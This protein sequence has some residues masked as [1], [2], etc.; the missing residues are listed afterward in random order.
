MKW[1]LKAL[2]DDVEAVHGR[3][4]ERALAPC[5]QSIVKR[6]HYAQYHFA[7]AHRLMA[8]DLS[9]RDQGAILTELILPT[10]PEKY[11]DFHRRREQ[12]EAHYLALM[13]S[14]HAIADTLA[15]VLYFAL[16]L[17]TLAPRDIAIHRVQKL[18]NE[19]ALKI[20]VG[21]MMANSE[22]A[23]VAEAV[24][25]SKHRSVIGTPLSVDMTGN[26]P[27]SH[28]LRFVAFERGGRHHPQRW[29]EPL[30]KSAFAQQAVHVI[31]IG[32][33]LNLE[34]RARLA[35][36]HGQSGGQQALSDDLQVVGGSEGHRAV[37]DE[38]GNHDEM[39]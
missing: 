7:E 32:V 13:Q 23:Y 35:A 37:N 14:M 12:A 5:L 36:K 31:E 27:Q 25:H 2:C 3:D 10:D 29:V 11:N 39:S 38:N 22:L 21:N 19:G 28:G 9:S 6:Q 16:G 1:D 33:L 24:N 17:S 34:L 8:D 4:H 18:L 30:V 15:H 20:A 26:E